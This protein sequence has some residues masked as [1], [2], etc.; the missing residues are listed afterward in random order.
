MQKILIIED[1]QVIRD[2]V[3]E[4]L[5]RN[6]YVCDAA[7]SLEQCLKDFTPADYQLILSDLRLP[8]APG[9]DILKHSGSVPVVIMTAF[10]SVQ[11]AVDAMQKGAKDYITK[12]FDHQELLRTIRR[13]ILSQNNAS[14]QPDAES[15]K[16]AELIGHSHE[17][18]KLQER[19][20]KAAA[21]ETTVLVLG[22]SG[23]GK[24]IVARA[25]HNRSPRQQMPFV[26]FSCASI[27][28]NSIE[29]ELFGDADHP[30]LLAD[31]Q[32]GTLFLDEIAELTETAQARLLSI[33]QQDS[34]GPA[35]DIRII[36][37]THRDLRNMVQQNRF[38]SDLYF[39]LKVIELVLPPL[40]ERGEDLIELAHHFLQRYSQ[41]HQKSGL[42][43]S[44][45]AINSLTQYSWP[46]NVRELANLIESAVIMSDNPLISA[47]TLAIDS[48]MQQE[49]PLDTIPENLSLEEY[50]RYFVLEHQD[51]M[52]ETELARKLGISR[53]A[54]WERRQ[55]FELP[56]PKKGA[57]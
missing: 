27:P 1:E 13:H 4:L 28:Q 54:L 5:T 41:R 12:P 9:I 30:G 42:S 43:F 16:I 50:F 11:S 6:N 18:L 23:T 47:Q 33:L 32:G 55:R 37:A 36:A 46:G 22:E 26:T 44:E 19:I 51:R 40:R 53:K 14:T 45:D 15:G 10:S 3:M 39:R 21:T 24:E 8:G 7:A 35:F 2:S 29:A 25:L 31:A 48:H 38:R 57:S 20:I 52:T 56:R 34:N 17:M 49:K